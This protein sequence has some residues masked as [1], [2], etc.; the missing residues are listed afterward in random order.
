MIFRE[1]RGL[2]DPMLR[3]VVT[4]F[5]YWTNSDRKEALSAPLESEFIEHAAAL[6]A[7]QYRT[8]CIERNSSLMAFGSMMRTEKNSALANVALIANVYV[9]PP[10]KNMGYGRAIMQNLE[11]R[12]LEDGK[13][14]AALEAEKEAIPFYE[15]LGYMSVKPGEDRDRRMAKALIPLYGAETSA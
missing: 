7:D 1:L 6:I 8:F 11:H 15:H 14:I 13:I 10:H 3:D 9:V 5:H 2:H 4:H 12:A